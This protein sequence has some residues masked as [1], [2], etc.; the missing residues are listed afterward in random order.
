MLLFLPAEPSPAQTPT[1]PPNVITILADDLGWGDLSRLTESLTQVQRVAARGVLPR[2]IERIA[3]AHFE[4]TDLSVAREQSPGIPFTP[5]IDRLVER[6][7][8]LTQYLTHTLCSPSRAGLL[9][10]RHYVRVG[11]GPETGGTLSLEASNIARDLQ[12]AGYA[13]GAFG[14]WH[15]GYPNFPADGNGAVVA[16]RGLTDPNNEVFENFKGIQWGLGVNAYGFDEW[17]GF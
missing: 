3:D 10:G 11:S 9:T 5:Q 17:Q 13:T 2:P 4:S 16:H 15:N 8:E 12:T 6:G 1:R 14:K 7:I